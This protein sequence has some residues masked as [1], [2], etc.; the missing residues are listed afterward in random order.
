MR[1]LQG[2]AENALE[3]LHA[4]GVRHGDL[5]ARNLMVAGCEGEGQRVAALDFDCAEVEGQWGVQ[6]R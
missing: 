2:S 5:V 1:G 6:R 3:A 4:R